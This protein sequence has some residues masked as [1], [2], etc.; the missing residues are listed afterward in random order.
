M[1]L[2]LFIGI[3]ATGKSSFYKERFYRTHVRVNYDMLKTRHREELLF[4]SCLEGKTKC[5]VDNTN[6]TREERARYIAPAKAAGF[7]VAGYFF[8]SRVAD[9]IRRNSERPPDER[10][11]DKGI[12]GGSGRL[13]LPSRSE[14]FDRLFFVRFNG[15]NGF[16]VKEW[17]DEIRRA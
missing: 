13:E 12:L 7:S 14:G 10:V 1:E 4:N 11:P 17:K 15:A 9:A 2:V 8:E 3:Q 5:V 16:E 6:L